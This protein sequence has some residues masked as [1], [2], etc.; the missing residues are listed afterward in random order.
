MPAKRGYTRQTRGH[1][2][3]KSIKL[4]NGDMDLLVLDRKDEIKTY[5]HL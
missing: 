4:N 3:S 1:K 2:M 5:G